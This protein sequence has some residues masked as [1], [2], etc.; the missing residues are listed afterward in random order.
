MNKAL[1][2]LENWA[3]ESRLEVNTEET[4]YRL[5]SLSTKIPEINIQIKLIDKLKKNLRIEISRNASRF[6]VDLK[7]Q[8]RLEL[9]S[10]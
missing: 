2:I 1:K 7:V 5:F 4:M 6:E 9:G 10:A 3:E 8:K